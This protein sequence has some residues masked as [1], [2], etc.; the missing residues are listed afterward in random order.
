MASTPIGGPR[1]GALYALK[2]VT[3]AVDQLVS[4]E[5]T[6]RGRVLDAYGEMSPV[7]TEDLPEHLR[8]LLVTIRAVVEPAGKPSRLRIKSLQAVAEIYRELELKMRDYVEVRG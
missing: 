8:P 3:R 7:T 2:C 6:I 1:D 5:W 4:G